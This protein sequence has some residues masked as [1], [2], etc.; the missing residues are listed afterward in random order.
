[1]PVESTFTFGI[2]NSV[3]FPHVISALPGILTLIL[4]SF[5][6]VL[7]DVKVD[8]TLKEDELWPNVEVAPFTVNYP[9]NKTFVKSFFTDIDISSLFQPSFNVKS[10]YLW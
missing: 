2:K 6:L 8:P 1:M 5:T 9:V 10:D 4:V 3:V 7:S